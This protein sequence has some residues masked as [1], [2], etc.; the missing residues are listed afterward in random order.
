MYKTMFLYQISHRL[1]ENPEYVGAESPNDAVDKLKETY[2]EDYY[3]ERLH[4][5]DITS[6]TKLGDLIL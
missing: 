4:D 3:G 2:R 6:V 1:N 5:G